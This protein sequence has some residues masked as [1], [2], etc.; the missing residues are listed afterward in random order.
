MVIPIGGGRTLPLFVSMLVALGSRPVTEGRLS[1]IDSLPLAV[2]RVNE[3]A[4][5]LT[6]ELPLVEVP[7]KTTILTP[8]FRASVPR[9]VSL[10]GFA[11]E[12]VDDAGKTVP[13]DRLHHFIMTD[14][15]RRELFLPLALPVF[16]A[17]KESP[18]PVLPK[19][20]F[21]F[22][23]QAGARYL[24]AAMLTNPEGRPRKLQVRLCL[25]FVDQGWLFPLFRVYPW[26]MDVKFPLGGEGGRHDFAVPAGRSSYN[27]EGSPAIPG[28]IVA[29]GGHA[30]DFVTSLQLVDV[31]TGDTIWHQTPIRDHEGHLRAVPIARFYRWYR[32]GIHITPA[33]AYRLTVVYDNPTGHNLP[34]GGMGSVIG[35]IVPDRGVSWPA[36]DPRDSIYRTEVRNLVNNM[37]GIPMGREAHAMH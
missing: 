28:T 10:Y 34:F 18:S 8:V 17:S 22:P 23:L 32:L 9:D 26:T 11:V 19:Y 30:H 13:R 5:R 24:A 12:I 20:L 16:G 7:P 27:W 2:T 37:A 4:G 3:G 33:H 31:T 15:G 25:S 14:L 35:L 1:A 36:V 6:I 29:M 21:G